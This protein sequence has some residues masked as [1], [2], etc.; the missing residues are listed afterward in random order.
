MRDANFCAG[1]WGPAEAGD[2][3]EA[4]L[5]SAAGGSRA[6]WPRS[7]SADL[8]RALEGLRRGAPAWHGLGAAERAGVL[9][10]MLD[11]WQ[12]DPR[13]LDALAAFL[14]FAEGDLDDALEGALEE[15]DRCLSAAPDG[16][17]G[18]L[19]ARVPAGE[20]LV[21]LVREVLPTLLA[22]EPVLLFA[23]PD[24]PQVARGFV[25]RLAEDERLAGAVAL[26][27]E[28]RTACLGA[29][30]DSGA[31]ERAYLP[32]FL[33][34]AQGA[35]EPDDSV[36]SLRQGSVRTTFGAGLLGGAEVSSTRLENRPLRNGVA[37]VLDGDD[38]R[39]E[40]RRVAQAAFGP[41]VSLSGQAAGQ[42]G[43]VLCHERSLSAFTAAL[44]ERV[45]ELAAQPACPLFT[46]GLRA[47]VAELRRLGL[48]EG[49]TLVVDGL[50]GP[51][52]FRGAS[53]RAILT[54]S[55]FT[56]V[57]PSMGLA[58]ATRPAP[59]LA[60]LRTTSDTE[61]RALAHGDLA[62]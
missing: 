26:L 34:G 48:D 46:R 3:F 21:G 15:G 22:G 31:F 60:L 59:V 49:A 14:G 12:D 32:G 50:E 39:R 41:R 9:G 24:L 2:G 7:G 13:D 56:N 35:G 20:L 23:D 36:P 37:L 19:L 25:A 28:D 10:A 53:K 1:S 40:A 47:H 58:K 42:V 43:Q 51:T 62:R 6:W 16:D 11:R 33:R 55:V 5:A 18:P 54:P 27:H 45:E 8:A 61:A 57:E 44:L 29:A 52:G 4:E 17:P 38:P 30:L